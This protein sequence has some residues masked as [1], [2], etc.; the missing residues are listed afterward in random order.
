MKDERNAAVSPEIRDL[1]LSMQAQIESLQRQ[2]NDTIAA[3]DA[4]I[5]HLKEVIATYQRMLFGSKSA[6]WST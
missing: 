4:E 3:K 2:L 5:A 6:M 1:L